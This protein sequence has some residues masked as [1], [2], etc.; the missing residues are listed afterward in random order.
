MTVP[1]HEPACLVRT[2]LSSGSAQT[3]E[4]VIEGSFAQ[5]AEVFS[6][7]R[8]DQWAELTISFTERMAPPFRY[9]AI[10]FERHVLSRLLG[11]EGG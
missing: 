3:R 1:W 2:H 5:V 6:R 11:F 7:F 4:I 8:T 9:E 10:D